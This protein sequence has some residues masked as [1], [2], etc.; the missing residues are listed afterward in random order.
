M[1]KVIFSFLL[2]SASLITA[3]DNVTLLESARKAYFNGKYEDAVNLYRKLDGL[4]GN[5]GKYSSELAQSLYRQQKFEE[6][7]AYY[8]KKKDKAEA[9]DM[10][11]NIGNTYF[12]EGNYEEAINSYREALKINPNDKEARHNLSISMRKKS[13]KNNK[14]KGEKS[15]QNDTPAKN[16]KKDNSSQKNNQPNHVP[17]VNG[18]QLGKENQ[19][20]TSNGSGPDENQMSNKDIEKRRVDKMLENLALDEMK[21]KSKVNNAKVKNR[22]I[23]KPW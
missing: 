3:Q 20:K 22:R 17:P 11:F 14:A 7:R 12:N 2:F 1:E 19:K 5:S 8:S 9:S 15:R 6:S 13:Q 16:D 10:N 21:T 4:T 18:D 23:A